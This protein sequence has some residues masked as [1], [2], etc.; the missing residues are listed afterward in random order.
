[1]KVICVM[2]FDA[3][4]SKGKPHPEV[5]DEAVVTGEVEAFDSLYYTLATLPQTIIYDADHFATLPDDTADE[6]AVVEQEAIVN[7]ETVPA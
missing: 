7:L 1:M 4:E 2:P 5:G 6:M 3:E